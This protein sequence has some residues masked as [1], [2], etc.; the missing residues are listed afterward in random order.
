M[1]KANGQL[2]SIETHCYGGGGTD[3][4]SGNSIGNA[5]GSNYEA[6]IRLFS[7]PNTFGDIGTVHVADTQAQPQPVSSQNV[8]NKT[9]SHNLVR[10]IFP[11]AE[12]L[13]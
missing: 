7:L 4:N 3:S 5:Y 9:M 6:F 11:S 10:T 2:V 8:I 12:S 13:I 1:R